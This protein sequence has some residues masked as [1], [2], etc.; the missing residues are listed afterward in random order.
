MRNGNS[1]YMWTAFYKNWGIASQCSTES[2]IC[3]ATEKSLTA[4]FSGLVLPNIY[5]M[6]M[7]SGDRDQPGLMK[8][9]HA[10]IAN[11]HCKGDCKGESTDSDIAYI[12]LGPCC[13]SHCMRGVL[14]IGV[15]CA[16]CTEMRDRRTFWCVQIYHEPTTRLQYPKWLHAHN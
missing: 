10:I 4:Y 6:Q 16:R 7:S 14:V 2:I 3:S 9:L 12:S 15:A 5:H 1:R 13:G 11:S 8:Q